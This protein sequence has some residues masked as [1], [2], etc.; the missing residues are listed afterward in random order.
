MST[1]YY[2]AGDLAVIV[3]I[4]VELMH[5]ATLQVYTCTHSVRGKGN[6]FYFYLNIIIINDRDEKRNWCY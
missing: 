5:H 4:V 1:T 6:P 3:V 2:T